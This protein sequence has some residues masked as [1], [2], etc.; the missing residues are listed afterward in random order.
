MKALIIGILA[1]T[2][3]TIAF[4]PQV[5]RVIKTKHTKDLSLTTF[6]VF[7]V[8]VFLWFIYGLLVKE[9]PVIFANAVTLF[10]A[11]LIVIMKLKHG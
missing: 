8:G 9:I 10:L 3:T 11:V 2:L 6:S 7:A 5:V 1:G 4:I